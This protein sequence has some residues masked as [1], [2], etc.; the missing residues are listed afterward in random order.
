MSLTA[1]TLFRTL[2]TNNGQQ[3]AGLELPS[4]RRA[5]LDA[6]QTR[7]A[8][9]L[10]ELGAEGLLVLE[11]ENFSW[12]TSGGMARGLLD[13]GQTPVLYFSA[14]QRWV[15][16]SNVDTQRLFDEELD[17]LGFQ[18]KEWPWHWG[19][20]QLL[21]DLCQGR[22]VAS[23]Q[24]FQN[25]MG[26]GHLLRLLRRNMTG[27]ERACYY[28]LGE[29]LGHALEATCRTIARGD[30]E[31]EVAG[32]L[33]HRLLHR[34]AFPLA[35][36]A[37]ADGRSRQYRHCSFTATPVQQYCVLTAAARKYGLCAMASRSMSFGPPEPSYR[38]E[39]D[40]ACKVSATY[41]A[42]SWP[43][44]VP[45]QILAT[46]RR[47]LQLCGH[48][49]EWLLAPQGHITGRAAVELPL[50]PETEDLF[51]PGW[52]VTW[53]ASVGAAL[54]CDTFVLGDEGPKEITPTNQW[55]LKRIRVQGADFFRPDVLQR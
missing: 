26:A 44:A 22:K 34:G 33:S 23:D 38:K 35:I 3:P 24:P 55:P 40:T 54:S 12:L 25:A 17:G 11:P 47:V 7:I 8:A 30:T 20:E 10:Q 53:N 49:H 46:G 2:A 9:L 4:D 5:D 51:Q 1:E 39:H 19:R 42:S 36:S 14:E 15:I 32:Q 31:R 29:L 13:P 50:L 45:R 21:A 16:S 41:Q 6:K 52:A 28:A 48:E 27:Y 18:L 37:A 43:D